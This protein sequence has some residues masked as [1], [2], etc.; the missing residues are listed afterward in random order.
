MRFVPPILADVAL[1]LAA[2]GYGSPLLA[3]FP[4]GVSRIERA[5]LVLLG[6]LGLLGTVL[7]L[8]GQVRF[9]RTIIVFALLPALWS[10][11]VLTKAARQDCWDVRRFALPLLPVA[12]IA[13]VFLITAIGGLAGPTGDIKTLGLKNDSIAYHF[14]GPRVWLRSGVIRPV[15]DESLTAMPAIVETIYGA[16]M[17]IGGQR[18]PSLFAVTGLISLLLV[19]AGLALRLGLTAR[20]TWWALSLMATMPI[21][22]RGAFGGYVDVVYFGFVLA[23]L[24]FA[25]DLELPQA[26]LLF[27]LFSGFAMGA[28]YTG[29]I[30]SALLGASVLVGATFDTS[31]KVGPA[32][33][34]IGA[35]SGVA[36]CVAAPWYVRNWLLLGC[37]VYPPPPLLSRL[38]RARYLSPGAI[39]LFHAEVWREGNGMGR[40]LWSLAM[41]P[42]HLTFHPANF[43]NGPGGVGLAP[44]ALAPF[45]ILAWRRDAFARAA[46]LFAVLQTAA[47]FI[48]EQDARFIIDV[49]VLAAIAALLGWRYIVRTC[50]RTGRVLSGLVV[51]CSILYGL[52]MIGRFQMD[53][54][55]AV[56]SSQFEAE[57]RQAEIPFIES[58]EKLNMDPSVTKV[59]FLDPYVPSYYSK[60]PYVKPFGRWGEQVLPNAATVP[61]VLSQLGHL[62]VSHILDVRW[63]DGA[64]E[65]PDNT[66]G[67]TLV[68][69]RDGQRIYRVN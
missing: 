15:P 34:R 13:A 58:F 3:V 42:F 68:F 37:P 38:F 31:M 10:V 22:Y 50:S 11:R 32:M 39:E 29:I 33:K 2:I 26:W 56:V 51:A 9:S 17:S 8:A 18:A 41:L 57:R 47:W 24:R 23:A 62:H 36:A 20:E 54:M 48:T 21:L 46:G 64:Y 61:Q 63:P 59:L 65:V 66:P 44:L 5:A 25:C 45:G 49:Y 4:R 27:G 60:K 14:L 12:I 55:H 7:F 40:N 19:A 67:L 6:G 69:S 43:L 16:L 30:A 53:N 28:K 35:A 52:F 1:L